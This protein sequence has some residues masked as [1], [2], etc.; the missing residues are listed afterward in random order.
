MKRGC[1]GMPAPYERPEFT[2]CSSLFANRSLGDNN[3]ETS[4]DPARGFLAP[5]GDLPI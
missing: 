1:L 5:S 2:Q 4:C 3:T